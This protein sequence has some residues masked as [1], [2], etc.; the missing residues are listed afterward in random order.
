MS[1]QFNNPYSLKEY[2]RIRGLPVFHGDEWGH[3]SAP[4]RQHLRIDHRTRLGQ[5]NPSE[6][7]GGGLQILCHRAPATPEAPAPGRKS[8]DR[9][10]DIRGPIQPSHRIAKYSAPAT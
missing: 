7:F 3:V 5:C 10:L 4:S 9:D 6:T 8:Q 2:V 1:P